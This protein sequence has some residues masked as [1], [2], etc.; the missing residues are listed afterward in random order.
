MADESPRLS[1]ARFFEQ[2]RELFETA[3]MARRFATPP[4]KSSLFDVLSATPEHK[5]FPYRLLDTIEEAGTELLEGL[6]APAQGIRSLLTGKPASGPRLTGE[7]VTGLHP[8]KA[9]AFLSP[10]ATALLNPKATANFLTEVV[11]DPLS[12]VPLGWARRGVQQGRTMADLLKNERLALP[13]PDPLNPSPMVPQDKAAQLARATELQDLLAGGPKP[14]ITPGPMGPERQL[15]GPRTIAGLLEQKPATDFTVTP[16]GRV[17]STPELG[18]QAAL[19]ERVA[20]GGKAAG[21]VPKGLP[22]PADF[23]AT[24]GGLVTPSR[25]EADVAALIERT[26]GLQG[27]HTLNL[28][29]AAE[30]RSFDLTQ[31]PDGSYRLVGPGGREAVA[32]NDRDLTSFLA[33]QP[34]RPPQPIELKTPTAR[35]TVKATLAGEQIAPESTFAKAVKGEPLGE[36]DKA[37]LEAQKAFWK[38][39]PD[40]IAQQLESEVKPTVGAKFGMEPPDVPPV[41][42]GGSGPLKASFVNPLA[43]P[44]SSGSPLIRTLGEETSRAELAMKA[45]QGEW[46]KYLQR[47]LTDTLGD[48]ADLRTKAFRFVQGDITAEEAGPKAMAAGL[49]YRTA[50]KD[51]AQRLGLPEWDNYATH[52]TDFDAIYS[53]FRQKF[54]NTPTLAKLEDPTDPATSWLRVQ[55]GTEANFQ[56]LKDLMS[57]ATS[58]ESVPKSERAAL[59]DLWHFKQTTDWEH[60][61]KFVQK[62]LPKE[63]FDPYLLKREGQAPYKEDL[64]EAFQR[65]VPIALKKI[66]LEPILQRWKPVAQ[67]LPGDYLPFTEKGY[68][69]NYLERVIAGRPTLDEKGLSLLFEK[70]NDTLGKELLTMAGAQTGTTLLRGA[71]YRGLIG[72]DSAIVN[73]S[74][75][76]NTW[77]ETGRLLSPM[78]KFVT[79]MKAERARQGLFGE[80]LEG[81]KEW[82]GPQPTAKFAQKA[83]Q[84]DEALNRVVLSPMGFT[85]FV[86]RGIAF[87]A[88]IEEAIAKGLTFDKALVNAFAKQSTVVPN[89]EIADAWGHALFQTIPKTQFGMGLSAQRTPYLRGPLGRLSSVLLTY[90]TQQTQFLTRGIVDSFKANDKAKLLRFTAT[91]GAYAALP[92]LA[93]EVFGIDIRRQFGPDSL[94]G[95]M[96]LPFYTMLHNG[97]N[98]VLGENP[99]SKDRA[100]EEFGKFLKELAI[101]QYRYAEKA[102]LAQKLGL[103]DKT[104]NVLDNLDRGY[105]VDA[106]GRFLYE[107]TPMGELLKLAGVNPEEGYDTRQL[108]KSIANQ[109]MEYRLDRQRGIDGLLL[110]QDHTAAQAFT[111]KWGRPITMQDL[112]K[113]QKDRMK[114]PQERALQMVPKRLR[115]RVLEQAQDEAGVP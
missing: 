60:L 16:G 45:E 80:Y 11:T 18:E 37:N 78:F 31:Q 79:N 44:A 102:G 36:A 77:A 12:F 27:P 96:T 75:S 115:G 63:I 106:H 15:T 56:R 73:L 25:A 7:D 42:M 84:F 92:V 19:V 6:G 81:A 90:P 59:K 103:S 114:P 107:S 87:E 72:P 70:V 41:T 93:A 52:L 113:A 50:M 38:E 74:Q 48:S 51:F 88:G 111:E 55:V 30:A 57:R 22:A 17:A 99:I 86:N 97:Y 110:R 94:W 2:S 39:Q 29:R 66:H 89:L 53:T 100:R 58:W 71:A 1:Q 4:A 62:A 64:V 68:I 32:A 104:N 76:L 43:Q 61:P 21:P 112:L 67:S 54:V 3:D 108:T 109:A 10:L 65:Y 9:E 26:T 46:G 69:H 33:E 8:G 85:E 13:A 14:L 20:G 47:E 49:A 24:P 35:K 34:V 101:P 23:T 40:T 83:L 5:A 98:A 91:L 28:E 105:A 95:N 82:H